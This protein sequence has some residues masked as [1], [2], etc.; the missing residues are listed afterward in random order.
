MLTRERRERWIVALNFHPRVGAV[1]ICDYRTGFK[2]PEMI[3]ER[4][5]VVI[6]PRL[7]NRSDL[8]TVVP[9]SM[10]PPKR[11]IKYQCRIELPMEAP[12]PYEGKFKWAKADMLAT[13]GIRR[14]TLPYTERD[15]VS[16][17]RKYLTIILGHEEMD[18]ITTAVLHA[19]GLEHLT[20]AVL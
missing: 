18:K 14:L 3:K 20:K 13:V 7:P 9:L 11:D 16:N 19:L 12:K 6:S 2:E 1:V 10:S 5:A 15:P 4:L 8:C 17:K